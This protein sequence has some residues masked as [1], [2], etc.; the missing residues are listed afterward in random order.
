M[1]SCSTIVKW[2]H[3][4]IHVIDSIEYSVRFHH[5]VF[6]ASILESRP[7]E[8][9]TVI[10]DAL[11]K[12]KITKDKDVEQLYLANKDLDEV[13]DLGRFKH[14]R[15]LWLNG[16]KLRRINCLKY[17][18]NLAE[19]HLQNN[20]LIEIEGALR[21]LTC[22]KVLML[23]NN[24]LTK[25]EKVV[26]EFQ[27]MQ[28]LHTLNLFN[29]P[30]AQEP[31]YRI[32]VLN[33][34]PSIQ[35]LDRQEVQKKE[36]D[37]ARRIYDQDQEKIRDTVAFG[38]RSEGPPAIY[39]P[40][41]LRRQHTQLTLGKILSQITFPPYEKGEDAINARRLKKSVTIYTSF[42]W[43]KLPLCEQRRQSDK[44]FDSPEIITHVY[45]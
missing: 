17:N 38:R 12:R 3:V 32:F 16:N 6:E 35:L 21:H 26:Q 5:I 28:T 2:E 30:I 14:L 25:L 20:H 19:L 7:F 43:S 13:I 45:R 41:G 36:R 39:Y 10:E 9:F 44:P 24:Q 15:T 29:N 23:Q 1:A 8:K 34:V 33:S 31:D 4:L 11:A 37:N 42:D 22:M 18:F 40:G 27:K